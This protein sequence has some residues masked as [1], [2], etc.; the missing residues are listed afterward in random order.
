[1]SQVKEKIV[2]D[3]TEDKLH[4][5][6]EQDVSEILSQNRAHANARDKQYL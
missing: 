6:H 1:M 4:I 2:L 5:A 3:R